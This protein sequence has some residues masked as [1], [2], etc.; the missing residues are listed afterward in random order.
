MK[1]DYL[2]A[3]A[4]IEPGDRVFVD[5]Y[6]D[7]PVTLIYVNQIYALVRTDKGYEW[8]VMRNRVEPFKNADGTNLKSAFWLEKSR[9]EAG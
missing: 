5:G 4:D 2:S 1:S 6:L 8:S 7:D 3:A 9:S